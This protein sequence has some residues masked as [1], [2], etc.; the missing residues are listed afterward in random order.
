LWRCAYARKIRARFHK[1]NRAGRADDCSARPCVHFQVPLV[2]AGSSPRAE[3]MGAG[4][5]FSCAVERNPDRWLYRMLKNVE[6][7]HEQLRELIEDGD[8]FETTVPGN[9]KARLQIELAELEAGPGPS[10]DD[11]ERS[12]SCLE[13]AISRAA[14]GATRPKGALPQVDR[15][16]G[17]RSLV[18]NLQRI[19]QSSGGNFTAHRKNGGKG[20]LVKAIDEI[21]NALPDCGIEFGKSLARFLPAPDQHPIATY[22]KLLRRARPRSRSR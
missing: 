11:I 22:E 7:L 6:P 3:A 4:R 21:R 9:V 17:L 18:V 2:L 15:Y 20:T 19:A 12:I 1:A 10:I 13:I 5:N 8:T 16:P 14:E